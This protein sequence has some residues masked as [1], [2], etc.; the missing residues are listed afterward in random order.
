[1]LIVREMK[2]TDV[3]EV[4]L[5][6]EKVFS[7][8]WSEEAFLEMIRC[9]DA[10]YVVAEEDG[11]ILGCSGVRNILG[12]GEITNVVVKEEFQ[13]RGIGKKMLLALLDVGTDAGVEAFILEVRKSNEKAIHLYESLGFV[14]E[15]IRKNFYE[16]PMEDGLIMWKRITV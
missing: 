12:E 10:Y 15:G 1:M 9:P 5:I 3:K 2:D 6:E 4:A 16:K 13:D 14:V 8:P 11:Q 7:M